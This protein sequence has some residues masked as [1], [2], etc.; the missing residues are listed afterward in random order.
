MNQL[1]LNAGQANR[2][3]RTGNILFGL[4]EGGQPFYCESDSFVGLGLA[5]YPLFSTNGQRKS[6]VTLSIGI[7]SSPNALGSSLVNESPA[8]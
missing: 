2:I 7:R 5:A 4:R 1:L 3:R 8:I 6:N